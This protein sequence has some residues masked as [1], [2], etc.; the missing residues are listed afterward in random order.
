MGMIWRDDRGVLPNMPSFH[1]SLTYSFLGKG[2]LKGNAE[3]VGFG[4]IYYIDVYDLEDVS[5]IASERERSVSGS[6][7]ENGR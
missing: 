3:I 6:D 4:E 1:M 2:M 5:K 7:S